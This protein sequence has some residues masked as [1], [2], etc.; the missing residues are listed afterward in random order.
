MGEIK[1]I[2]GI[3]NPGP[4]YRETRHN[5]G[6]QV[7][8]TLVR[9]L[10]SDRWY[11]QFQ[12]LVSETIVSEKRVLLI[13]PLTY[14]NRSG[15]SAKAVLQHYHLSPESLLVV[16][17]D[18]S[19]PFESIRMRSKGSSG[20][21]NGLQSIIETL[22][23]TAFPRLRIGTG[24]DSDNDLAS[25]VLSDFAPEEKIKVTRVIETAAD[26]ALMWIREG[27]EASMNRYNKK[28]EA[29]IQE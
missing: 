17:D 9:M 28:I 7:T 6:F 26:A 23:S 3:G 22:G 25:Y 20:S 10:K 1:I 21:H 11:V 14:V 5:V 29:E 13:K 2:L 16:V 19:L 8:D 12:A 24:K 27:I 4:R 18:V 15:I